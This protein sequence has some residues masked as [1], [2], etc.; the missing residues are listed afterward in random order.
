MTDGF[1]V[2]Q[3]GRLDERQ[4]ASLMDKNYEAGVD[5]GNDPLNPVVSVDL[6]AQEDWN[7]GS[8]ADAEED[9]TSTNGEGAKGV[10]TGPDGSHRSI[11]ITEGEEYLVD[12]DNYGNYIPAKRSARVALYEEGFHEDNDNNDGDDEKEEDGDNKNIK[13]VKNQK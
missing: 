13:K 2:G 3:L 7:L 8:D 5:N 11:Q 9:A 1:T 12:V 4:M 10:V 6:V